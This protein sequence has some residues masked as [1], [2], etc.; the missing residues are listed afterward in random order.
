M[1]LYQGEHDIEENYGGVTPTMQETMRAAIMAADTGHVEISESHR[2]LVEHARSLLSPAQRY[3]RRPNAVG[4]PPASERAISSLEVV[5]ISEITRQG[6][7]LPVC[8]VC[9]DSYERTGTAKKLP[10]NHFYHSECL[11]R[12]L[13]SH[14]SCP[15]CRFEIESNDPSYETAKRLRSRQEAVDNLATNMYN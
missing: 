2:V 6:E 3:P 11:L 15:T 7:E 10:C 8:A 14:A 1:D 13:R 9:T 12:W 5:R 4:T